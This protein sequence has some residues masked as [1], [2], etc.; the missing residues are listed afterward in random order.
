M[1]QPDRSV[2]VAAGETATLRCTVTSLRPAGPVQWF[3][4]NGPDRVLVHSSKE[5]QFPRV[6]SVADATK[7]NN[8][9]FSIHISNITTADTGVYYCVKFRK[10]S[11]NDV[12]IASGPGTQLTV[13]GEC[14]VACDKSQ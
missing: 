7:R 5:G 3:R 6:T 1:I 12:E 4:G 9:D 8:T 13:S 14:R 10:A 11:P 2:S